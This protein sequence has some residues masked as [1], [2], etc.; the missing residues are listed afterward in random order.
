MYFFMYVYIYFFIDFNFFKTIFIFYLLFVLKVPTLINIPPCFFLSTLALNEC[1]FSL[2]SW[3]S[4]STG[5][6]PS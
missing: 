2:F 6:M 1:G 3:M 4:D 5:R